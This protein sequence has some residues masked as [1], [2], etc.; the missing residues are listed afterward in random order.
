ME[1]CKYARD[2]VILIVG[3]MGP[4]AGIQCYKY[5]LENY[6]SD[7]T[8]QDNLDT[9]VVSYPGR[10]ENRVD[11]VLGRSSINPGDCILRFIKPHLEVLMS[12][13]KKVVVG[14]PCVT[15]HCPAIFSSFCDRLHNEYPNVQVISIVKCTA[16]FI[17]LHCPTISRIGI[18]STDGTRS[19]KPFKREMDELDKSLVYLTDEQQAI[20]T[21]CIFNTEWY[22]Y[23][24]ISNL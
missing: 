1:P 2:S 18:M 6:K 12:T 8:D 9:V 22:F 19:A 5:V 3:G 24:M 15:F 16:D 13:H 10:I 7:G 17:S 21:D 20:V 4:L 11:Y 23:Y 14:I